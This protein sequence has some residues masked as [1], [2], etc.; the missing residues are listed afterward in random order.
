MQGLFPPTLVPL[1]H[2]SR[3]QTPQPSPPL[4]SI[5]RPPPY[6]S[7]GRV[8]RC[9]PLFFSQLLLI[10]ST[11][12][13]RTLRLPRLPFF[14]KWRKNNPS[15]QNSP[16]PPPH[17]KGLPLHRRTPPPPPQ[18]L[19]LPPLPIRPSPK[20]GPPLSR[21]ETTPITTPVHS[22]RCS[23]QRRFYTQ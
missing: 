4:L 8:T 15:P 23:D 14:T 21:L 17:I 12:A 9:N 10:D 11:Q 18:P 7:S 2:P 1:V 3:A 13:P 5:S 6:L 20:E 19:S 22:S 16:P